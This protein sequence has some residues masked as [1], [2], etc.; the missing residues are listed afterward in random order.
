MSHADQ[1]EPL[2]W[3][4]KAVFVLTRGVLGWG[5][6][7]AIAFSLYESYREHAWTEPRVF[8]GRLLIWGVAGIAMGLLHLRLRSTTAT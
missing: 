6:P 4:P 2:G 5:V 1:S 7:C 8:V 3:Q